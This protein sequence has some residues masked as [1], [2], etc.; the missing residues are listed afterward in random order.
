MIRFL[1]YESLEEFANA[2]PGI[3]F[4]L[5]SLRNIGVSH[6]QIVVGGEPYGP[7]LRTDSEFTIRPKD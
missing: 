3:P 4:V 6:L 7:V 2:M 5:D 1:N